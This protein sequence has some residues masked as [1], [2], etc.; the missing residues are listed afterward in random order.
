MND[1]L[2]RLR[3]ADQILAE[4]LE[5][6]PE[7]R[8][9]LVL[10]SCDGDQPLYDEVISLLHAEAGT[11]GFLPTG[12]AQSCALWAALTQEATDE[13]PVPQGTLIG[14]YQVVRELGRGG[15]GV[16]YLAE[17]ADDQFTQKVAL[18][19]LKRGTDTDEV[20]R[21]FEQE[22]QILATLNH[23]AIA[24]LSDGGAAVDGRPFF[25]M[26]LV[27]GQPVDQ[28]C[29]AHRLTVKERLELFLEIARAVHHAHC[30]LVV[31][32]DLKPSNILVTAE[33]QVKLLDFGI[34]KI[35]DDSAAT[36]AAPTTRT[37]VRIM[38]PQ[39]ASP[40][41][42]RGGPVTTA[43]DV[44]QLGLLLHLLLTGR[45]PY[46]VQGADAV[47]V[48]QM[49]CEQKP[50][51]PSSAVLASD[52]LGE[53][54]TER[55]SHLRQLSPQRLRRQL[56]GDLDTITL[57]ALRKEPERRY[58]S[59]AQLAQDIERHLAGQ[60][61]AAR[62]DTLRYRLQKLLQRHK[63]AALAV[64]SMIVLIVVVI[65]L[66]TARLASERDRARLEADK[67]IHVASFMKELFAVADPNRAQG[68]EMLVSEF[69]DRG[70]ERVEQGLAEQPEIQAEMLAVLGVTY[71]NLAKYDRARSMLERA[72]EIRRNLWDENHLGVA[73][74]L[75][76][77]ARLNM[78]QG[79][80]AEA[81]P[82]FQRSIE[83]QE[84]D[85][86]TEAV[87]LAM[88]INNLAVLFIYMQ[89]LEEAEPLIW[90]VIRIRESELGPDHPE[91]A[92]GYNNLAGIYVSQGRYK[93]A[94]PLFQRSLE[95]REQI[96]GPEHSEVADG[97]NNLAVVHLRLGRYDSAAQLLQRA[98]SIWRQTLGAEHPKLTRAL[99]NLAIIRVR[100]G[101]YSA[102]EP[103]F[104]EALAARQKVFGPNHPKVASC[105]FNLGGLREV[106]GRIEE[107]E[108]LHRKALAIR[109]EV[110]G[111]D[112][113]SVAL[114]LGDIANLCRDQGRYSE[115][116]PLYQRAL[117]ILESSRG[118]DDYYFALILLQKTYLHLKQGRLATAEEGFNCSLGIISD[119]QSRGKVG[120]DELG[121]Q[122]EIH[123]ALGNL[124]EQRDET[125][126]ARGSWRRALVVSEG[127]DQGNA[128][129]LNIYAKALLRLG[130]VEESRPIVTQVLATELRDQELVKL[131]K[132]YRLPVSA[133]Q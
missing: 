54:D 48:E 4:V 9:E 25:A 94:E 5:H 46:R 102:A 106:Q 68:E 111:P 21:R 65:G 129:M 19:L 76:D 93:E 117:E 10:R 3:K 39:Y 91:V 131:C 80:Y 109:E 127:L 105:M 85:L 63:V 84:S 108:V 30:N 31:H 81:E 13:Q 56:V 120:Q 16:V 14:A 27:E 110:L 33:R 11:G 97:S 44:Y 88:T 26:E 96:F 113:P 6:P 90:R 36:H 128:E 86:K 57:M 40:E 69:L 47:E 53:Q 98:A 116:E 55:V 89:R 42:V 67:A 18:K 37:W 101:D 74:S 8:E 61:V 28:Y 121:K 7:Q 133:D 32:R 82:L 95:I 119:L 130:R 99:N 15:M 34:A 118:A 45:H 38:T 115:A 71:T 104:E 2:T 103:L 29:D 62:K 92:A 12:G 125:E 75:Q 50:V 59:A 58:A 78:L 35:L 112:N 49:I 124:Y 43:S 132:R 126:K 70:A 17:R 87:N 51:L 123:L 64:T 20:I 122:A 77:L 83:I 79:K 24:R 60:P 23:P 114:S 52:P 72:L 107:A 73:T 100:E 66:F 1:S 41:Q 22:R